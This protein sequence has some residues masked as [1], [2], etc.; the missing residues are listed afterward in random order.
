[1][2]S[3]RKRKEQAR[4]N[5]QTQFTLRWPSISPKD[6]N[7]IVTAITSVGK[8][9]PASMKTTFLKFGANSVRRSLYSTTPCSNAT[10]AT[11]TAT[12]IIKTPNSNTSSYSEP[13]VLIFIARHVSQLFLR[14]LPFLSEQRGKVKCCGLPLSSSSLGQMFGLKSAAVV[15]LTYDSKKEALPLV[16]RTLIDNVNDNHILHSDHFINLSI[17]CLKPNK[18]TNKKMKQ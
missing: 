6:F 14:H 9:F 3:K 13:H 10:A 18:K 15:S 1:M 16:I 12:T 7:E 11:T 4:L 2:S 5:E 8:S 17:K